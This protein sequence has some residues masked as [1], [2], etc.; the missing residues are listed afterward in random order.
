MV[1]P[2]RVLKGTIELAG[3]EL[4]ERI[5]VRDKATGRVYR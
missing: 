3:F 4:A 1:E 2:I 5:V